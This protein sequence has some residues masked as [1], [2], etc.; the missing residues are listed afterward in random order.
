MHCWFDNPNDRKLY[1]SGSFILGA[2]I[3]LLLLSFLT[4]CASEP[5]QPPFLSPSPTTDQLDRMDQE[6]DDWAKSLDTKKVAADLF[7]TA[8]RVLAYEGNNSLIVD[9]NGNVTTTRERN[10]TAIP[11]RGGEALTPAEIETLRAS[12]FYA[13]PPPAVASCCIPRHGFTF[14]DSTGKYLGN[15]KVCYQCGC[16]TIEPF[17]P[18]N[19]S[20]DWIVWDAAK[21]Q[22]ILEAH[23]L[24]VKRSQSAREAR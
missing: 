24:K 20:L 5:E 8:V 14:Y 18:P 10:S 2:V 22:K 4:A 17:S 3:L 11:A 1:K 16:A 23:H 21:I 15:L 6:F 13:P 7:P 9:A 12:V 19:P